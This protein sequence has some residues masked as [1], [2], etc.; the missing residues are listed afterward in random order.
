MVNLLHVS[1]V[2]LRGGRQGEG[3]GQGSDTTTEMLIEIQ[4]LPSEVKI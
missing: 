4:D 3:R 1:R 2:V